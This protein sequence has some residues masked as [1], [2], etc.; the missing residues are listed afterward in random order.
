MTSKQIHYKEF[1]AYDL[2]ATKRFFEAALEWQ[3]QGYGPLFWMQLTNSR[4]ANT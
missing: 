3:F 1:V 2:I 4:I